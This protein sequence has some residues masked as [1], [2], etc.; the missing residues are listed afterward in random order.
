VTAVS[1]GAGDLAVG[2]AVVAV[3]RDCL[4][5]HATTPVSLVARTPTLGA[6]EAVTIPIAFLTAYYGLHRLARLSRGERVLIHAAAGGVGL[7]AVQLAH[8]LGAEVFATAGSPEKRAYLRSLGVRQVLD[9][10][11][12]AFAQEV[13]QLTQGEGVDV[14]LNSLAGEA[15]GAGLSVLRPYGRFVEIGKQ[16]IYQN[17]RLGLAPFQKSLSYF[18]VD[19]DRMCRERPAEVGALLR[20]VMDLAGAG[21]LTALPYRSFP[22]TE[23]TDAFRHVAQARHIGKVVLSVKGVDVSVITEA[24][25]GRMIRHDGTYLITGGTGGLGLAVAEWLVGQ[26]AR[27]LALLGRRGRESAGEAVRRLERAGARVRVLKA[28]VT[29]SD[30]LEAALGEIRAF[31]PPVRGVVHA[32]GVLDDGTVLTLD[33]DQFRRALAPKVAGAWNGTSRC[34]HAGF[35]PFLVRR[36]SAGTVGLTT[37]Q[38]IL[39]RCA[40]IVASGVGLPERASPGALGTGRPGCPRQP[41]WELAGGIC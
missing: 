28:D 25:P 22:V 36:P 38:V 20:E 3:A 17:A 40:R 23:V 6:D 39:S 13:L 9:S 24:S 37:L 32:A 2:D 8:H 16:D 5:S 27:S 4:G 41:G 18:A 35:C 19:L 31:M 10:R 30:Q 12:L 29:R 15:I 21:V 33:P 11:S 7:A 34:R 14:V 26:G 1:D